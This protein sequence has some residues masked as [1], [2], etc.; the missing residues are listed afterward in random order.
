MTSRDTSD[1]AA[2]EPVARRV[3]VVSNVQPEALPA[4][5]VQVL[6][7][8]HWS[9]LASRSL[10]WGDSSARAGMF[11]STLSFAMVSLALAGQA[12]GFGEPFRIFA[13]VVLLV[14]LF[15]GVGT[16]IRLRMSSYHDAAC[17]V[18]MNR[19]RAACLEVIPAVGTT[20]AFGPYRSTAAKMLASTPM[21]IGVLTCFVAGALAA[22]ASYELGAST[23]VA[24]S[25]GGIGFAGALAVHLGTGRRHVGRLVGGPPLFPTPGHA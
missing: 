6:A 16:V 1:G 2:A 17:V 9:L 8:E 14:V 20:M 25:V 21:L 4:L 23:L 18:G 24:L 15:I 11:L 5:T 22:I 12:S 10:A 13:L 19:I 7:T 3:P